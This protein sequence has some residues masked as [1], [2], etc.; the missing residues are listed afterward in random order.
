MP[1]PPSCRLNYGPLLRPFFRTGHSSPTCQAETR[2]KQSIESL[3]TVSLS[4]SSAH[5]PRP[6]WLIGM[7]SSPSATLIL[8]GVQLSLDLSSAFDLLDWRLLDKALQSAH[9]PLELRNQIMS[10]HYEI[11]YIVNHMGQTARILC[12][13]GAATGVQ[14]CT[15]VVDDGP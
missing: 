11:N 13:K 14:T 2:R 4:N 9:T 6:P 1:M 15:L 3:G 12:S 10:W 5:M 7:L 8:A